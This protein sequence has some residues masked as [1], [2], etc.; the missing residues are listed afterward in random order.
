MI[1]KAAEELLAEGESSPPSVDN[2]SRPLKPP[3]PD[4]SRQG[5]KQSL[6]L[7]KEEVRFGSQGDIGSTGALSPLTSGKQTSNALSRDLV[8]LRSANGRKADV[9]ARR[10]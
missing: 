2:F 6:Q 8:F 7:E 10:V 4:I 1:M 5:Q 3:G 9:A